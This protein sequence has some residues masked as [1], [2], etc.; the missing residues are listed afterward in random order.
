[1]SSRMET[2][3]L[4]Y[5]VVKIPLKE[6]WKNAAWVLFA[7][8]FLSIF[9]AVEFEKEGVFIVWMLGLIASLVVFFFKSHKRVLTPEAEKIVAELEAKKKEQ[10][11]DGVTSEADELFIN[12][13]WYIRYP[14]AAIISVGV[15][16]YMDSHAHLVWKDWLVIGIALCYVI[17]LA[18]ELAFLGVICLGGY[19]LITAVASLPV[20]AAIIIGAIIIG[21][22]IV[23]RR[24]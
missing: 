3:Q 13:A 15:I 22:A 14:I 4:E 23:N 19:F 16:W 5:N 10:A 18:R 6:R 20:S 17:A 21:M 1:M 24:S 8:Y 9:A 11:Q 7:S 12:S 2:P